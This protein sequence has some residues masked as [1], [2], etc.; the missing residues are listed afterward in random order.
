MHY[1]DENHRERLLDCLEALGRVD[2]AGKVDAEYGSAYYVITGNYAIWEKARMHTYGN[3]VDFWDLIEKEC[4][5]SGE[6]LIVRL[7]ANL[8]NGSYSNEVSPKALVNTL[9]SEHTLM[10]IQAIDILNAGSGLTISYFN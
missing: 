1:M 2:P 4:L 8:F 3:E 7:A 5:S 6:A 9:D 10:A